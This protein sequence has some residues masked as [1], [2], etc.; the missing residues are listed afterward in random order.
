LCPDQADAMIEKTKKSNSN[1]WFWLD[2]FADSGYAASVGLF[3]GTVSGTPRFLILGGDNYATTPFEFLP[4]EGKIKI[5]GDTT[6]SRSSPG[7]LATNSDMTID[8]A[9]T[10]TNASI[11][12]QLQLPLTGS[13]GGMLFYDVN[14]YRGQY[15]NTLNTN[16]STF[17]VYG[18]IEA[19]YGIHANTIIETRENM[20]H[21]TKTKFFEAIGNHTFGVYPNPP[22]TDYIKFYDKNLYYPNDQSPGEH[23]SVR[24]H[25][26]LADGDPYI[27]CEQGM[28]LEKD[29]AAKG[30]YLSIEGEISLHSGFKSPGWGPDT[31]NP[32]I[33]LSE[34]SDPNHPEY[35]PSHYTL[36]V[37][38]R[39]EPGTG[40]WSFEHQFGQ[41]WGWGDFACG[42]IKAAGDITLPVGGATVRFEGN[43]SA[44]YSNVGFL[45]FYNNYYDKGMEFKV[46]N[47]SNN[48]PAWIVSYKTNN[49]TNF[50]TLL[51][52]AANGNMT[53]HGS[54]LNYDVNNGTCGTST[55]YW[56]GV[57]A[58]NYYAINQ[59]WQTWDH[60]DDIAD[61]RAMKTR[62]VDGKIVF[63]PE[64]TRF[65][66]NEEGFYSLCDLTGWHISVQRKLLEKIDSLEQKLEV[67]TR[68]GVD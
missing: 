16:A 50:V 6:L 27:V 51:E 61:L 65:L 40:D 59:Y 28:A 68:K 14:L 37:R 29:V 30:M 23:R 39:V 11:S 7:H 57:Y 17:S 26:V 41:V 13:S 54:I 22:L 56:D 24:L 53:Y 25:A 52:M 42:K 46:M 20:A 67:L 35:A 63:D 19:G 62:L 48:L 43:D 49:N 64:T 1:N 60:R 2:A 32:F 45:T 33:Q 10:A 66:R 21:M 36:E 3:R 38:K 5:F 15:E 9:L 34:G 55:N 12:G 47:D 31:R 4:R 18:D 8:G 44:V 58:R